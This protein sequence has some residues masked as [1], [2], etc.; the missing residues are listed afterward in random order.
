MS[1]TRVVSG[2]HSH[3]LESGRACERARVHNRL[4]FTFSVLW[5][6]RGRVPSSPAQVPSAAR[7][8]SVPAFE[9][10]APSSCDERR[11]SA[12]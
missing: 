11:F 6:C 3:T 2:T 8:K 7:A 10:P 12:V 4:S 5:T 1:G 9:G